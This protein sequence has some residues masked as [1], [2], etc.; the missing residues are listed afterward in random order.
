NVGHGRCAP[1]REGGETPCLKSPQGGGRLRPY[2]QG[3]GRTTPF[4]QGGGRTTPYLQGGG[5]MMA[6]PSVGGSWTSLGPQPITAETNLCTSPPNYAI[7][8]VY[9]RA[10]GRITSLVGNPVN[11]ALIYAGAAR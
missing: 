6:T 7:C 5:R 3:G 9:G 10:S 2:M 8:A 1:R 11:N 4:L